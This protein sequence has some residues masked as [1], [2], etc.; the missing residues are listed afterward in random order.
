MKITVNM[1]KTALRLLTAAFVWTAASQSLQ[2]QAQEETAQTEVSV[3]S[4]AV[5][6]KNGLVQEGRNYCYYVNGQKARRVW[7]KVKGRKYYFNNSG[8]AVTGSVKV[9][10]TYYIFN[11]KGQLLAP[12]RK[13]IM[14]VN[15]AYYYVSPAGTPVTGWNVVR[16]RLYYSYRNGRCAANRTIEDIHFTRNGY[17]MDDINTKLKMKCME[18]IRKVTTPTASRGTKLRQCWYYLN[19]IRFQSNKFPDTSKKNWAKYCAY[20]LLDTMVGNCYGF[21]NA[22]AALAKELGYKPYVIEIPLTHCWVR[23]NGAYWDNMGNK[24]GVSTS[25]MLYNSK[26]IYKF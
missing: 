16:G 21:A 13:A 1:R 4:T 24:M 10:G 12:K 25:P 3:S 18:V 17:A 15:G 8:N 22:F 20:D 14:N 9:K 6:R 23:I 5:Q 26:Q 11:E 19:A 2:V 7:K